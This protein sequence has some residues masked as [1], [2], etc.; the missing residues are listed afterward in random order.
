MPEP[1]SSQRGFSKSRHLPVL[2][3]GLL[4]SACSTPPSRDYGLA[5]ERLA[6]VHGVC[7]NTM[8]LSPGNARFEDCMDVLS[9]TARQVDGAKA[10][11]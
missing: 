6:Q 7:A 3:I 9:D 8:E 4:L 11:Q 10:R 2:A 1:R 5:P